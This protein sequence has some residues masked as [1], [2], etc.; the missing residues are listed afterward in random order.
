MAD[1]QS[2]ERIKQLNNR[3]EMP[4]AAERAVEST[5]APSEVASPRPVQRVPVTVGVPSVAQ[6]AKTRSEKSETLRKIEH[7]LESDL[8]DVYKQLPPDLQ[9]AF[10]K[11]G[12]DTAVQV[13]VLLQ[14]V[15]VQ[16][17]KIFQLLFAWLKI[18]PGVNKYFL[19]QEAKLKTDELLRLKEDLDKTHGRSTSL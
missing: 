6:P 4:Q 1:P 14:K 17:K 8:Q 7:V 3:V 2:F 19:E 9:Q 15:K 10:R 12:E 5:P 18:I 11:R 16:T 13:E